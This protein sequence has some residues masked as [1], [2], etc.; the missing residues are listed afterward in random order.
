MDNSY[1]DGKSRLSFLPRTTQSLR[2]PLPPA[3]SS[4]PPPLFV[5]P[6]SFRDV[7]SNGAPS[8]HHQILVQPRPCNDAM[9]KILALHAANAPLDEIRAAILTACPPSSS[10]H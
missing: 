8:R 3:Y 7:V 1:T 5:M 2:S 6:P 10:N 9:L 4:Y